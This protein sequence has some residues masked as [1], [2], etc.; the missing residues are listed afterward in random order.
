[1]LGIA[2]SEVFFHTAILEEGD[3]AINALQIDHAKHLGE[4]YGNY[5][6][7]EFNH[8][9][10]AFFYAYAAGEWLFCDTLR[11]CP[12]PHSAHLFTCAILQ[13]AFFALMLTL[14]AQYVA[15]RAVVPFGLL[16]AALHFGHLQHP[17]MSV[18]P[19]HVLL[20]PF[21][22]FLAA[23]ISFSVGRTRDLIFMVV[24]GGFLFH[25]HV[26]QPLFVGGLGGLA[27]ALTAWRIRQ[28]TT[29]TWRSYAQ[30]HRRI[31]IACAAIVAVF[32]LP[33]AID[34]ATLG[35]KSNV[36]TI[37]GRFLANREDSKTPLQSFLYF[38]SFAT[39]D[40]NQ[41]LIF[42]KP[43]PQIGAFFS[44]HAG[45][46]AAWIA[47]LLAPPAIFFLVRKR[48]PEDERRFFGIAYL[49]LGA[50]IALTVLWG[51]AQAGPMYNFNGYFYYGIYYFGLLLA[52]AL[53]LRRV[54][55]AGAVSLGAVICAIAAVKFST[56]F[57]LAS[58]SYDSTRMEV[59][60]TVSAVLAAD[61]TPKK[62]K[63]LVFEHRDW[64]AVSSIALYLQRHDI[65]FYLDHWWEFMFGQRHDLAVLGAT[66]EEEAKVWWIT[67]RAPDGTAINDDVSLFTTPAPLKPDQGEIRFSDT[68][69]S[70]RYVV[71]GVQVGFSEY[72]WTVAPRVVF[73]FAPEHADRDVRLIFEAESGKRTKTEVLETPADV[74][75]NGKLLGRVAVKERGECSIVVPSAQWNEKATAKLEL[76]FPETPGRHFAKRPRYDFYY[77]WAFWRVSTRLAP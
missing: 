2:G 64:P 18:W 37:V 3:P 41:E 66:P 31:L 63:L 35:L 77:G 20:M 7:Y 69:N 23:C 27:L 13:S 53:V 15:W 76:R 73:L 67:K 30:E 17:F 33:L 40:G 22:A 72:T 62:P 56:L 24:A 32:L 5:S 68:G 60:K 34:V 36:A 10:P 71:S 12:S 28:S 74:Y 46:V 4:L 50:T 44:A 57:H 59:A 52:L 61:A 26:A 45:Q 14:I 43:G 29:A 39:Y 58:W 65:P 19:P 25:G 38:L 70:F 16:A 21:L 51:M 48:L 75:F 8:P 42:S 11:V 55:H 54:Q 1:M 49:F 6:R 47:V 9:G